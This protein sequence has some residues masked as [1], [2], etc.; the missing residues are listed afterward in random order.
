MGWGVPFCRACMSNLASHPHNTF[1]LF[2][3]C[4]FLIA[5]FITSL[6]HYKPATHY[7][8]ELS[9]VELHSLTKKK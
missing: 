8:C 1:I 7:P 9:T 5:H 4:T 6:G 3:G 2:I